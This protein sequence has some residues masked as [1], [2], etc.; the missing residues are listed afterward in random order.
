MDMLINTCLGK[1]TFKCHKITMCTF[2]HSMRLH[3]YC[4][5]LLWLWSAFRRWQNI[6]WVHRECRTWALTHH[7]AIWWR[8]RC[9]IDHNNIIGLWC[10][11]AVCHSKYCYERAYS[12]IICHTSVHLLTFIILSIDYLDVWRWCLFGVGRTL[13]FNTIDLLMH[14]CR[15]HHVL[16]TYAYMYVCRI[17]LKLS[18]SSMQ[19]CTQSFT[20]AWMWWCKLFVW[21][22]LHFSFWL[23]SVLHAVRKRRKKFI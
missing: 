9:N 23:F 16:R 8:Q 11:V 2:S 4:S 20:P 15:W 14:R 21:Q 1:C 5:L 19:T 12:Y 17:Q 13:T 7:F 6:G 18:K 3:T 22:I 10:L